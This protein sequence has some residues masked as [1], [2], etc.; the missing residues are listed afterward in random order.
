M[1]FIIPHF[2]SSLEY[3]SDILKILSWVLQ[4][5]YFLVNLTIH[6]ILISLWDLCSAIYLFNWFRHLT[7]ELTEEWF[8][9]FL[10]INNN[11]NVAASLSLFLY[12][13]FFS[14]SCLCVK[15][16]ICPIYFKCWQITIFSWF[17]DE[18]PLFKYAPQST[19]LMICFCFFSLDIIKSS[20]NVVHNSSRL[21]K[22]TK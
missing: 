10:S 3:C 2:I 7:V 17:L 4:S 6:Q 13:F 9:F 19:C 22:T 5:K 8:S 12:V 15:Q 21:I 11:N 20:V 16:P 1:I 14:I 18:F